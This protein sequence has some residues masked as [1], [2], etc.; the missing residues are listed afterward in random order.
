MP[1]DKNTTSE[2]DLSFWDNLA[3]GGRQHI[4]EILFNRLR[5]AIISGELPPGY[6]FPNENELCKKL[7]IGRSSLREAYSPLETLKLITRSKSGTYVNDLK[8]YRNTMNFDAIAK[9]TDAQNLAE[10][11]QIVEVG[12]VQLAAKKATKKDITRLEG[13]LQKMNDSS[14]DSVALS[15]YDFE[16]HSY[17]MKMTHNELL[18]IMFNSIRIAYK[19]FTE[20]VFAMDCL[21]QTLKEHQAIVDALAVNDP[22]LAAHMMQLHLSNVESFRNQK[23]ER[24]TS[25]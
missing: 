22:A 20:S 17:L 10:Y 2:Q 25:L 1:L 21:P 19:N 15:Q 8:S 23:S 16:F 4:S 9:Q 7:N 12:A 18:I 14:G 6:V 13:I 24:E 11:R 3:V 5:D